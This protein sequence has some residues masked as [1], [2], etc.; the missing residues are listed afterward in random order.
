[1][2]VLQAGLPTGV[3]TIM[4]GISNGI[5]QANINLFGTDVVDVCCKKVLRAKIREKLL[6]L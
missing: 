6:I 1:V 3:H 2:E 5:I 4:Y